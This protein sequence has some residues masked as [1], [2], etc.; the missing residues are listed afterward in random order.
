[1]KRRIIL[2][3]GSF[4][5]LLAALVIYYLVAGGGGLWGPKPPQQDQGG[6]RATTRGLAGEKPR[7][8]KYDGTRLVAI[9]EADKWVKQPDE[10][11]L[12]FGPR[13]RLYLKGGQEVHI[14]GDEGTF[15]GEELAGGGQVRKGT[16]VGN[17][18]MD[19]LPDPREKPGEVVR[20]LLDEVSFDND[21]L[22]I[23]SD[24][25]VTV[26]SPEADIYGRGLTV[27]WND[28]PR[29][30]RRLEIA[31]GRYMVIKNVPDELDWILLPGAKSSGDVGE[32]TGSAESQPVADAVASSA[33]ATSSAT[34]P[35]PADKPEPRNQYV[36]TFVGKDQLVSVD[37]ARGCLLNAETLTFAFDWD[38]ERRLGEKSPPPVELQV[39]TAPT[40]G[41]QRD[42]ASIAGSAAR[43]KSA[44]GSAPRHMVITWRG[45]LVI[46]P[47]GYTDQPSDKRYEVVAKG[48]D[49]VLTDADTRAECSEFSFK[50]PEQIGLLTGDADK[51]AR[52]TLVDGEEIECVVMEFDR[53]RGKAYLRGPGQ[54]SGSS[55]RIAVSP[56][57]TGPASAPSTQATETADVI[58][59][60]GGV[61]A[62]F[63]EETVTLSDGTQETRPFITKAKFHEDV[64]LTQGETG[65]YLHC[66][67]L[68]VWTARGQGGKRYP[69][70]VVATGIV[71]ARQEG[72]DISADALE[73]TF[74][75]EVRLADEGAA[76]KW[77]IY[78]I[79]LKAD[80]NVVITERPADEDAKSTEKPVTA[81]CEHLESDPI[82][83]TAC[84]RGSDDTP[85][86]VS[87]GDDKLTGGTIYLK[88]DKDETDDEKSWLTVRIP[89]PGDL[90]FMT[91]KDLG[92][93]TL[94][95]PCPVS[96]KW[97]ERMEYDGKRE[98]VTLS[99]D[100]VLDRDGGLDLI[101][102]RK[103][104]VWFTAPA[105]QA[106]P[107]IA[108]VTPV[109]V[110]GKTR[111]RLGVRMDEY[112][113]RS[114]ARV[115]SVG[116]VTV[117]RSVLDK[118]KFLLQ[119]LNLTCGKL[120][121]EA[122][123]KTMTV[124]GEGIM[125]VEDYRLP[126]P[127]KGA[128]VDRGRLGAV[129]RPWQT[130]F[131]WHELMELSR[132]R[133]ADTG[134]EFMEVTAKSKS[135]KRVSMI[136]RSGDRM[137]LLDKLNMPW[138]KDL[139]PGRIAAL[140]CEKMTAKFGPREDEP[141]DGSTDPMAA[142]W[143]SGAKIGPLNTFTAVGGVHL[144]DKPWRLEGE[145]LEYYRTECLADLW[146][147]AQGQEKANAT[148][149]NEEKRS[150][151]LSSPRITCYLDED[152]KVIRVEASKVRGYGGR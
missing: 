23:D 21:L 79:S 82:K 4:L 137:V 48:E 101:K 26:H 126:K 36:A 80:G 68:D 8:E 25:P 119:R 143:G 123:N 31:D 77:E 12:V 17:V 3:A 69:Q 67:N 81:K 18:E 53:G 111:R 28:S 149:G 5:T 33:P 131:E 32:P 59:W 141:G 27:T 139:P 83:R 52:V 108:S 72:S 14:R 78:P 118:G 49:L 42:K 106:P 61:E 98:R 151:G 88:Q 19:F 89:G 37:S 99:G 43:A 54:L 66:D 102:C 85:A 84:L 57:V 100:V 136:H 150:L 20:I 11:F 50:S 113:K 56:A 144:I 132:T 96:V 41:P 145:R 62:D 146:G 1:M 97:S 93:E 24:S 60:K 58:T 129:E 142:V 30:L 124:T 104:Q 94:D 140:S 128:S 34:G 47:A 91:D 112:S 38:A 130:R 110:T 138:L 120:A 73:I 7:Y 109:A 13:V 65:D 55:Q 115:D 10:S 116:D 92:G 16:L 45:P 39:D 117:R 87:V 22:K 121:Y 76:A 122:S 74:D 86:T 90:Y 71:S 134:K 125:L 148:V 70:R 51:P 40:T 46:E 2:V 75:E 105:A 29:E 35:S 95:R 107:E 63:A 15:H 152:G 6:R 9:Y 135:P 133:D 114:I 127:D 103:M 44:A 147:Y 64:R